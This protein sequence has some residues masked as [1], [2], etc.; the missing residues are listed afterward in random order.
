MEKAILSAEVLQN[1]VLAKGVRRMKIQYR[2]DENFDTDLFSVGAGQFVNVYLNREDLLLP[3]PISICRAEEDILTLVYAIVGKGTEEMASYEPGTL[4]RVSTP[5]GNGFPV[6]TEMAKEA[7]AALQTSKETALVIGGGVGVPP[8]LEL[9]YR[10]IAKGFEVAAVLGFRDEP[11]LIEEFEKAGAKVYIA[12]E[13][14][15]EG[16]KG[17]V[18]DVILGEKLTADRYFACGP[19]PMLKALTELCSAQGKEIAVSLEER[20]GCGYGACVGCT[21]KIK[22][23]NGSVNKRVCKDGPVFWGSEVEWDA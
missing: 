5:L 16:A 22:K 14:G 4:L 8:L 19:K 2:P 21:C 10:L 12:T 17:F 6:K 7:A 18:T 23:E 3:R 1:E 9:T 20:M 11:F 13:S 15:S